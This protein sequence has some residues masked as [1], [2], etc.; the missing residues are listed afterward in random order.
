MDKKII[1]VAVVAVLVVA[2]VGCFL[3][4]NKDS[5]DSTI[6]ASAIARVNTDGSGL[7]LKAQYNPA[8]FYTVTNGQ[9][10]F[11][12][13]AWGGKV[14]GTPGSSSIQH[15]QLKEIATSMGLKFTKYTEGMEKN[16]DT[17]YFSDTIANADA[18]INKSGS[19]LDGGILWE[20]QYS[21]IISSDM[22]QSFLLTNDVFPG[23]TCCII[24][25]SNSFMDANPE[26]TVAF[27]AAYSEAVKFIIKA[28]ADTSSEDYKTLINICMKYTSGLNEDQINAALANVVYK[29]SDDNVSGS[30][31]DLE[32]DIASLEAGLEASGSITKPITNLGFKD[33]NEFAEKIVDDSYLIKAVSGDVKPL[34]TKKTITVAAIN[35]DVHQIGLRVAQDLGLFENYNL[36][37]VYSGLTNGGAV[38]QDLLN[39]HSDFGF[40]G[41]PP[42]T[43]NNVNGA[44]IHA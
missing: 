7:Y 3:V 22:Y 19:I 36:D 43:S 5:D 39:G 41:A 14:F 2:A 6:T 11:N 4:I 13:D 37:V 18:A 30:L 1:A 26:A 9:Y 34:E 25:G 20:P 23:H 24:A 21:I 32:D 8:D 40:L 16:K 28:Q 38:A 29:F 35:G 44:Y 27:L 33:S 17:L 12:A 31:A 42:F 15:V 10:V